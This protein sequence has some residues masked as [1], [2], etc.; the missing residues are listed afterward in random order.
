M[1]KTGDKI[2]KTINAEQQVSVVIT[3]L[4]FSSFP[5]LIQAEHQLSEAAGCNVIAFE[6][7]PS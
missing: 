2:K 3:F 6:S 5:A 4:P 7:I 1:V